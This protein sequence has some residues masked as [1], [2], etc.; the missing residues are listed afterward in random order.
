MK[1]ILE[2]T[3]NENYVG[4]SIEKFLLK[5]S[6]TSNTITKLKKIEKSILLNGDWVYMRNKLSLN[7][8]LK[9]SIS[10]EKSSENILPVK[11]DF[12]IVYE[13]DDILVVNKPF[14]MPI[15]PSLNNYS[16]SLANALAYYYQNKCEDFIFRCINRL[17]KDTTGL[18]IIAK[19]MLSA[20]ILYK[21]MANRNIKRT[22]IAI[23]K[24][25]PQL[26]PKASIDL[27]IGR[28]CDSL[29][30]RKV[31]FINGE[32]AIT[33]YEILKIADDKAMLK[34][35]LDTGRTHQIRV[36]LSFLESPLI[37]DYLYNPEYIDKTDTRPLLHSYKLNFK[38]PI[39]EKNMEFVA[40]LPLDMLF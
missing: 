36:H 15:H 28:V 18:T 32:R 22:Y 16:N 20:G 31:D 25:S 1:R 30:S 6:Y 26:K 7:D 8:H 23:V 3:I 4:L 39:S 27:P 10:E 13:D 37:G 2:Y 38:H 17:D 12:E 14:N 11:L 29:I 9:V 24:N 5:K 35:N 40:P 19:N 34:L 33:H 21:D